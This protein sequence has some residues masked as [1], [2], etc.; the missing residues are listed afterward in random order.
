MKHSTIALQLYTCPP[1]VLGI[2]S[3]FKL[4]TVIEKSLAATQDLASGAQ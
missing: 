4:P 3:T 2:A 1:K